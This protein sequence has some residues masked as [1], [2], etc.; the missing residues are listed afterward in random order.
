MQIIKFENTELHLKEDENFEFLLSNKEVALGYGTT[1]SLISQA[2]KNHSNE[3]IEGKH[4]LTHL[5]HP[6]QKNSPI[7]PNYRT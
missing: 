4:Y 5:R 7:Q 1:I 3:L 2:K 6:K